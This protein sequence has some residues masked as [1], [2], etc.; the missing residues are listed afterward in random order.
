MY[1]YI[2]TYIST[3]IHI[4]GRHV[5]TVIFTFHGHGHGEDHGLSEWEY[6]HGEGQVQALCINRIK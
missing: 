1:T 4:T 3:Y 2:H 5:V 6:C